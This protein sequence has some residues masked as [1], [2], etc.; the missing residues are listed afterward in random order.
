MAIG[1]SLRRG[2]VEWIPKPL[3][4]YH[5]KAGTRGWIEFETEVQFSWVEF[6]SNRTLWAHYYLKAYI[7]GCYPIGV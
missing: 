6:M 4:E 5:N 1:L 7:R 2:A 3:L